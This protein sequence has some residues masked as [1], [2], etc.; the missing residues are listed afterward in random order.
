MMFF[1][2]FGHRDLASE[3]TLG[4]MVAMHPP[5]TILSL[6]VYS[7]KTIEN[8]PNKQVLVICSTLSLNLLLENL[9]SGVA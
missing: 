5:K 6:P 1:T 9:P 2:R 3:R 7:R 4:T 8:L